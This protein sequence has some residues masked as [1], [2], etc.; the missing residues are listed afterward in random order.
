MSRE[1]DESRN[2]RRVE[3]LLNRRNSLA[4]LLEGYAE[5]SGEVKNFV[6]DACEFAS[7]IN[8]TFEG[9][10]SEMGKGILNYSKLLV[11]GHDN[12]YL[13]QMTGALENARVIVAREMAAVRE[14][15]ERLNVNIR[16]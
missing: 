8:R 16:P 12:E 6:K 2:H 4:K 5:L 1:S 14:E 15:L 7:R 3:E 9:T 11:N 13:K 10:D